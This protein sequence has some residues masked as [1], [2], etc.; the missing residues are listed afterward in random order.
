MDSLKEYA[1]EKNLSV[2]MASVEDGSGVLIYQEYG[3]T[4]EQKK[5]TE[6]VKGE[7]VSFCSSGS[8]YEKVRGNFYFK[9]VFRRESKKIF[10]N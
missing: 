6:E 9:W 3:F 5:M 4:P 2:D 10:Q 1:E 7:P 8:E